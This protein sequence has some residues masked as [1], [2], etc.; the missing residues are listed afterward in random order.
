MFIEVFD[1]HN[2]NILFIKKKKNKWSRLH[3]YIVE[4]SRRNRRSEANAFDE[5][6][7]K[8]KIFCR[9]KDE[10]FKNINI[11]VLNDVIE[12]LNDDANDFEWIVIIAIKDVLA[13]VDKKIE[14]DIMNEMTIKSFRNIISM[15]I[16][17]MKNDVFVT[18]NSYRRSNKWIVFYIKFLYL[19]IKFITFFILR[20]F[21]HSSYSSSYFFHLIKYFVLRRLINCLFIIFF[22]RY[23]LTMLIFLLTNIDDE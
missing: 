5:N 7:N 8:M 2:H 11:I 20:R 6:K 1:N 14:I 16:K 10:N 22:N 12:A 17:M 4:K 15:L 21:F 19:W 9:N 13:I 23:D 3:N 18:K